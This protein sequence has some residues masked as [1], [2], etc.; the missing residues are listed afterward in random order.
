MKPGLRCLPNEVWV[1]VFSFPWISRKQLGEIVHKLGNPTIVEVL[2]YILHERGK[3]TLGEICLDK[4]FEI[5][6]H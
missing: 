6:K 4:V 2:Q 1:D 5:F 3:R